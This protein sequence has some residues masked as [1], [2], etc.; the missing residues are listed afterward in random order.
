ME[1]VDYVALHAE[2]DHCIAPNLEYICNLVPHTHFVKRSDV[3][4]MLLI[5]SLNCACVVL[6]AHSPWNLGVIGS[7]YVSFTCF[8]CPHLH[9]FLSLAKTYSAILP[10]VFKHRE[11]LA[12]GRGPELRKD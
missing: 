10:V 3:V 9:V 5:I 8:R 12:L 11:A 2:L 4:V 7:E 6:A 1:V